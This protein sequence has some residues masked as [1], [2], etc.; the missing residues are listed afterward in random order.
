MM[1]QRLLDRQLARGKQLADARERINVRIKAARSKQPPVW[2][3][4]VA[5]KPYPLALEDGLWS[6][7]ES[8]VG[9]DADELL[10]RGPAVGEV[11]ACARRS[12]P[13]PALTHARQPAAAAAARPPQSR[14][15]VGAAAAAGRRTVGA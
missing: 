2:P 13:A 8:D 4:R 11:D 14:A 15:P 3:K 12:V 5:P 10:V 9:T 6:C 1:N 7:E